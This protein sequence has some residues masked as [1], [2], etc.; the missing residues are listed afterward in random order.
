[1]IF[2]K[3]SDKFQLRFKDRA[4]AANIL[5][6]ALMD[7]LKSREE[8]QQSIVLGIPRG[9]VIVADII[10]KKL[11]CEFDIII[12]HKLRAPHNEEVAIGAIMEDGTTYL[13]EVIVKELEIP[14]EYIEKEKSQQL[15]E[16]KRRASLYCNNV[17]KGYYHQIE[18]RT[19]ILADDGAATGATII[20]AAR[21]LRATKNPA[22]F[23]IAIPVAPKDTV[24]LLKREN[25]DHLEVITS[26]PASNF[27]SVGQYYQSFEP[28]TDE[29]VMKIMKP[30]ST[31]TSNGI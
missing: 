9:G 6:A 10:A 13:N 28:V 20:A 21:W 17:S 2:D 27:K 19:V 14:K 23:I 15:E 5:A 25:I 11:S 7:N 22:H 29:Q 16:I 8:R 4:N 1:M 12:P 3:V 30:N 31:N 26:P 24:N 18:N